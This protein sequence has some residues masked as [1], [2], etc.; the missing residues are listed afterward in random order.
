MGHLRLP[1]GGEISGNAFQRGG[2]AGALGLAK[3]LH[4]VIEQPFDRQLQLGDD[5]AALVGEMQDARAAIGGIGLAFDLAGLLEPVDNAGEGD[6][7]D[8][9]PLGIEGLV[10]VRVAREREQQARL[11][12]GDTER[13]S[14]RRRSW[15]ELSARRYPISI[16]I[17]V[18][19]YKQAYCFH[20]RS[21]AAGQTALAIGA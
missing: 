16:L 13:S 4:H 11:R 5:A 8:F 6:R 7:L 1:G 20:A 15:R 17:A 14:N 10:M 9:E 21:G 19:I 12:A 3:A 2:K 18:L